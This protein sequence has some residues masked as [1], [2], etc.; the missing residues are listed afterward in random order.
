[1]NTITKMGF[2]SDSYASRL[3]IRFFFRIAKE[4]RECKSLIV[5]NKTLTKRRLIA[6]KNQMNKIVRN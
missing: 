2:S 3:T 4:S 1:M 5:M 6:I